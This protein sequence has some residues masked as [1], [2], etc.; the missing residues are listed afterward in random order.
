M[1]ENIS[2]SLGSVMLECTLTGC[3]GRHS[4]T[5]YNLWVGLCLTGSVQKSQ[6]AMLSLSAV[7]FFLKSPSSKLDLEIKFQCVGINETKKMKWD[8]S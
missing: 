2:S 3:G 1:R 6:N 8:F 4:Q 7:G 5:H